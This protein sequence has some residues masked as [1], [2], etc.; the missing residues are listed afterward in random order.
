MG[1]I[2]IRSAYH[3]VMQNVCEASPVVHERVLYETPQLRSLR[4]GHSEKIKISAHLCLCVQ[5]IYF[6]WQYI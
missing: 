4:Q 6:H 1:C 5:K 2:K 3:S